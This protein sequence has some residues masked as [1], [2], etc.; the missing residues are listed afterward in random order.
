MALTRLKNQ[1]FIQISFIWFTVGSKKVLR[2]D[3]DILLANNIP[4]NF[5]N[6]KSMT[7]NL[8]KCEELQLPGQLTRTL[9]NMFTTFN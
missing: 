8:N 2:L 9:S 1:L 5:L 6:V 7:T 4:Y 3:S